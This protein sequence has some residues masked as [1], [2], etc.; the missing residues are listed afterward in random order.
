MNRHLYLLYRNKKDYKY[1]YEKLY[2][3]KLDK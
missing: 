1:Y 3:N 2:T